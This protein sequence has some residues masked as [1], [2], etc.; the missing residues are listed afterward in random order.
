[1][2]KTS[3]QRLRGEGFGTQLECR[4]VAIYALISRGEV[5]YVGQSKNVYHRLGQHFTTRRRN[6]G[7]NGSTKIGSTYANV[8]L[9]DFDEV[10]LRYCYLDELD[11][12]ELDVIERYRPRFNVAI[13]PVMPAGIKLNL[14]D[15]PELWKLS[16][17]K[18]EFQ[19]SRRRL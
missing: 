11:R 9:F 15:I 17:S 7:G 12:I 8:V 2:G 4:C 19:F 14:H 18:K 1:M 6:R 10:L 16:K 13:R 5:V 3:A